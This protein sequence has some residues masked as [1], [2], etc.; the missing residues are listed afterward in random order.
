MDVGLLVGNDDGR[1]VEGRDEG[2]DVSP[3]FVGRVVI[4]ELV[5][6][7][8]G[9]LLVGID[10][11]ADT[12]IKGAIIII[13]FRTEYIEALASLVRNVGTFISIDARTKALE[14]SPEDADFIIFKIKLSIKSAGEAYD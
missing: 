7:E 4:G 10:V 14:K 3:G 8:V 5:G 1:L 11:G 12:S 2:N 6:E 13:I 9:T